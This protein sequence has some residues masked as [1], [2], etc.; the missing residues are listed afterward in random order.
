MGKKLWA[1][2]ALLWIASCQPSPTINNTAEPK[3]AWDEVNNP[4]RMNSSFLQLHKYEQHFDKLPLKGSLKNK[5]WTGDYWAT[6]KGGISYRWHQDG[7]EESKIGYDLTPFKE[8]SQIDT[9]TLSPIEKFDILL[10]NDNYIH[11]RAE[12]KRTQVLKTIPGNP[13][14]VENFSIPRW[15]GLCHAWSPASL[16]FEEPGPMTMTSSKG[17]TVSLGSSDV[18]A[19]LVY[20]LAETDAKQYFLGTRCEVDLKELTKSYHEGTLPYSDFIAELDKCSGVNPGAFHIV[21]SNQIGLRGEGFIADV[22]PGPEVWNQPIFA[23]ESE[24]LEN[25]PEVSKDAA[26]GTTSMIKIRTRMDYIQETPQSWEMSQDGDG[27][28]Y[29]VYDYRLELDSKGRIIG[30]LWLSDEHPDFLW[31]QSAPKFKGDFKLVKKI[32]KLSID[33][34]KS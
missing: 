22:D 20:F 29:K 32:Y 16:F 23:F 14:Y 24:L 7:T 19:L 25:Y 9:S 4:T 3:K 26:P 13:E 11:T 1:L 8:L 6:M 33:R 5:P 34:K 31:K 27:D 10:G 18:K 21:I 12:R 15:E 28:N 2:S 30:G 17:I